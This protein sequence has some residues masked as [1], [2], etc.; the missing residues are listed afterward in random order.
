[1]R[2]SNLLTIRNLKENDGLYVRK[3][4]HVDLYVWAESEFIYGNTSDIKTVDIQ[5][6]EPDGILGKVIHEIFDIPVK[7]MKKVVA[8]VVET[9]S[10]D[11]YMERFIIENKHLFV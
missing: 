8:D 3:L 10:S 9:F 4:K 11:N 6:I 5:I 1:M 2:K 7:D